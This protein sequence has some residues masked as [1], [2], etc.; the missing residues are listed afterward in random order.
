[1]FL[2]SQL[3][4]FFR[5]QKYRGNEKRKGELDDGFVIWTVNH[6]DM[7]PKTMTVLCAHTGF[8]ICPKAT[9][10]VFLVSKFQTCLSA[11]I[12]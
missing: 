5:F 7:G 6:S 12:V 3:L 2:D 1:M 8:W 4:L 9:E 11:C 10:I